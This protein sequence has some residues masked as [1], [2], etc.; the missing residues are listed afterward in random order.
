M[1]GELVITQNHFQLQWPL[2][3]WTTGIR[4]ININNIITMQISINWVH[5]FLALIA[6]HIKR[7][8]LCFVTFVSEVNCMLISVCEH[9]SNLNWLFWRDKTPAVSKLNATPAEGGAT[10]VFS[11][12]VQLPQDSHFWSVDMKLI[13]RHQRGWLW[14]CCCHLHTVIR[15]GSCWSCQHKVDVKLSN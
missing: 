4:N 6:E 2:I 1:L 8:C 10:F 3:N 7:L 5:S 9:I 11:A 13:N 15:P 14:Q 12:G